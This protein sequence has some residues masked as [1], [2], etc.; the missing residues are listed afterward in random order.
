[1][2]RQTLTKV[3]QFPSV[4]VLLPKTVASQEDVEFQVIVR[5][6]ARVGLQNAAFT[7]TISSSENDSLN[8]LRGNRCCYFALNLAADTL[9]AILQ[10]FT[11]V[12]CELPAHESQNFLLISLARSSIHAM[13]SI[14]QNQSQNFYL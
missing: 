14:P 13:L 12:Y 11:P 7:T 2:N 5:L 4:T 3:M 9:Q 8:G 6:I 1:M 10:F